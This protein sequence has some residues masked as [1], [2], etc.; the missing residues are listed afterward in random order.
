M[1][2]ARLDALV[3]RLPENVL[4]LSGFWPMIG[5]S[6]LIFPLEGKSTCLVPHCYEAEFAESA[7]E[8]D[9]IHFRYGVLD[10][11]PSFDAMQRSLQ[12][13]A[14]QNSWKRIGYEANFEIVAPSWN[15]AELIV[16]GIRF[17]ALLESSF[18]SS[19]FADA[20]ELIENERRTKTPWEAERLRIASEIS[21]FGLEAFEEILQTGRTGTELVADVERAVMV[22]GTGY[23]HASRVRAF[24]QVATGPLETAIG[25]R[26]NEV[27]TTRRLEEHDLAILELGVVADGYWADRTRVRVAGDPTDTQVKMFEVVQRAQQSAART[28]RPGVKAADV[29]RAARSVIADAGYSDYFP[30][31]T[32]HGLGFRYHESTPILSPDS[33]TILEEGMLTSVEPGIYDDSFGGIR[34]EDDVLV[35][36]EGA[37]TLGPFPMRLS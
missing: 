26:P 6:V 22:K 3:L 27:S 13:L 14:A 33:T 15:A 36:A 17:R 10:A 8:V 2:S 7:W 37:E 23:K 25:Y 16:P 24:A 34:L 31:V 5:A 1:S 20:T 29:D 11:E 12:G 9:P 35:T 28:V 4:L 30:H 32:G 18:S 19:A 21:N